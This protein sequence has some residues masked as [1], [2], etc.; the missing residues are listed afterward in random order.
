[1]TWSDRG[2]VKL[3]EM[4]SV[5]VFGLKIDNGVRNLNVVVF[6]LHEKL[7]ILFIVSVAGF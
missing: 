1:M 2:V 4:G 6:E 5:P 7:T 3:Q